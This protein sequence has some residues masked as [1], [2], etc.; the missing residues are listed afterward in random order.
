MTLEDELYSALRNEDYESD[1]FEEN[2]VGMVELM[3]GIVERDS[4]HEELY[5][6]GDY[7]LQIPKEDDPDYFSKMNKYRSRQ[8]G[9]EFTVKQILR[10]GQLEDEDVERAF[11]RIVSMMKKV[12]EDEN[13]K[14]QLYKID[15]NDYLEEDD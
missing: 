13:Y 3:K 2:Y 10:D 9:L 5:E 4:F 12:V 15:L 6:I 11:E 8:F 1:Y 7:E 14:E